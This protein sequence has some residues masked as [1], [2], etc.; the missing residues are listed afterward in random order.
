MA[1]CTLFILG[2][3][4]YSHS[5]GNGILLWSDRQDRS[6]YHGKHPGNRIT[7]A[8][9]SIMALSPAFLNQ[10][11]YLSA[12]CL[13]PGND[14]D[15]AACKPTQFYHCHFHPAHVDELSVTHAG[16]ADPFGKNRC[17]QQCSD[18]FPSAGI[19]HYQYTLRHYSGHG[20]QLPALYGT[21]FI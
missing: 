17:H 10:Y 12:A 7:G 1:G 13:S 21:S 5:F 3:C 14:S 19:K 16:M 8:S 20:L 18:I 15:Q 4:L 2:G 9:E 11:G 6:L